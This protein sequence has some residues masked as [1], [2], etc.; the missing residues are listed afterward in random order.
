ME[1]ED[2]FYYIG[3]SI[4]KVREALH[5]ANLSRMRYVVT[6]TK[7]GSHYTDQVDLFKSGSRKN[8][9]SAVARLMG[10]QPAVVESDLLSLITFI[11]EAKKLYLESTRVS[12]KPMTDIEIQEAQTFL[13]SKTLTE[14]ILQDLET[15]GYVGERDNKLLAYLVATSRKLQSPLSLLVRSQSSS[16]KSYLMQQ[17]AR[18][19]PE[20]D[21]HSWSALSTKA[22]YYMP[23]DGLKH[24]LIL[25]DEREGIENAEYPIRTLQTGGHLTLA[26]PMRNKAT[27]DIE[28][29]VIHKTGP[30]SYMDGSTDNNMNPENAN[31]CFEI[32]LD[33]SEDQTHQIMKRQ[34]E[35]KTLSGWYHEKH[36][37]SIRQKHQNAQRLLKPVRIII[38]FIDKLEFP[39]C[40]IRNRRDHDRFISLIEV[41]TFLHQY[42][43]PVQKNK[44]NEPFIEST[45][46][47]YELAY[48]LARKVLFNAWQELPQP[49]AGFFKE[50]KDIVSQKAKREELSLK[51][52]WFTRRELRQYL[53]Y[54]DYMIKTHMK[55]LKDLEYF[56]VKS[57]PNGSRDYYRIVEEEILEQTLEGLT[58]PQNLKKQ[59]SSKKRKSG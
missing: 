7:G 11:E 21:V 15:L 34:R 59:W 29:S 38:P 25:I 8:F 24:K 16:G 56:H 55:T 31:R 32:H 18:L 42:Q 10:L 19:Q 1:G 2:Y 50:V 6:L 48:Q 49:L 26:I 43:R 37:A 46:Q 33:E 17:I 54:P 51:D 35:S 47:D 39:T 20:E 30:I 4:Y 14:D 3:S 5:S 13:K 12:A 57:G 28:T 45:L 52:T 9:A 40:F 44:F 22:L 58:S 36:K 27:G 23:E 41:V 53:K